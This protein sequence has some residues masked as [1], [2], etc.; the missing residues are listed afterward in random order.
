MSDNKIELTEFIK[1]KAREIGFNGIGISKAEEIE[2]F[3][4]SLQQWLR[5][6][7]NANMHYMEKNFEKR[8]N[9]E[10]LVEGAKSVISL[11]ISYYPI[12]HQ[13]TNIPQISK[14]AYGT[15]YHFVLKDKMKILWDAIS[16][17]FQNLEGRMFVDSAPV[18]DKLWA[19]KAGLG[20]LG[21]NSCLINKELGSFI[22]ICELIVNIEL[23]YDEPYRLNF[24]GSCTRCIDSCPTQAIVHPGVIDSNKCISYQTI[25]NK[26]ETI[27]EEY[28]GKFSNRLFGCDICQDVCPWNNGAME[29]KEKEFK[30]N[31]E[32][33]T[34]DFEQWQKLE[35]EDFTRIFKKS[36]LKRAKYY[37]MIRNLEFLSKKG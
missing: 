24:C 4:D 18:S 28:V 27:P 34:F 37:G 9:P 17:K 19:L 32:F 22:F 36:P 20:W 31:P 29:T 1:Q 23:E 33:F 13:P 12:K 8:C 21:K 7:Y 3:S 5:A 26:E 11:I 16:E 6:G 25:E 15:D 10:L 2:G 35:S 14:Y 30:P